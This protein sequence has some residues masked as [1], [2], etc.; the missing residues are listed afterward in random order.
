MNS[1][2]QTVVTRWESWLKAAEYYAKNFPQVLEIVNALEGTGQL[3]VKAKKAVGAE[4]LPRSLR[5]IYQC[6][7]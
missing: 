3:V 2:L 1:P 6:F 7:Y 4:S 5:E